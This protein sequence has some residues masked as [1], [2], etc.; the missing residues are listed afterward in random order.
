MS[1]NTCKDGQESLIIDF[2][3]A[4]ERWR[5]IKTDDSLADLAACCF[6]VTD[7]MWNVAFEAR[8][9]RTLVVAL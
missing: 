2:D 8:L 7:K 6:S 5:R 9:V 1:F 4:A 3:A